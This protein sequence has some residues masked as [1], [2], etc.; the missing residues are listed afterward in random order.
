[1]GRPLE[2]FIES[3][4]KK[5]MKILVLLSVLILLLGLT[6]DKQFLIETAD[7]GP[8]RR[9]DGYGVGDGW[10]DI[11]ES[12]GIPAR[13]SWTSPPFIPDPPGWNLVN[14]WMTYKCH[15]LNIG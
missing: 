9:S 8:V 10:Y 6:V 2:F 15:D 14:L 3:T 1:M 5:K 11:E 13:R 7:G 4:Q 12:E